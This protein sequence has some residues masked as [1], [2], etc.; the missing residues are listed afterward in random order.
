M[1]YQHYIGL[2]GHKQFVFA[3]ELDSAGKIVNQWRFATTPK[4]LKSFAA[5]LTK[6]DAVCLEST[7]N[8]VAIYQLIRRQAGQAVISNSLQMRLLLTIP[9]FSLRVAAEVTICWSEPRR[10]N[11]G[12]LLVQTTRLEPWRMAYGKGPELHTSLEVL[13]VSAELQSAPSFATSTIL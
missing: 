6:D 10:N 4:A 12:L 3:T 7:T 8:A 5:S 13:C 2:D 11:S 9:G 1:T